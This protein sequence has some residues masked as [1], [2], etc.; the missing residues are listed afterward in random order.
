MLRARGRQSKGHIRRALPRPATAQRA[1]RVSDCRS[2]VGW[3]SRIELSAMSKAACP[4]RSSSARG[5]RRGHR[6]QPL[7]IG[8][9]RRAAAD[10][11]PKLLSELERREVRKRRAEG[12]PSTWGIAA[13]QSRF[14][15]LDRHRGLSRRSVLSG[16]TLP[17]VAVPPLRE[18]HATFRCWR[19]I[20]ARS[21][22]RSSGSGPASC[23]NCSAPLV[24]G[25]VRE[26]TNRVSAPSSCAAPTSARAS[27]NRPTEIRQAREL[28]LRL[29]A[30][31]SSTR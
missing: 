11:Q 29:S 31:S 12:D 9:G 2:A 10:L 13:N 6:R 26:L 19:T 3:G 28:A 1:V 24:A 22:R 30:R 8:R 21:C 27:T 7:F 17:R 18:R 15:K 20:L 5:D 14:L 25:K 16:S 23:S 4:A